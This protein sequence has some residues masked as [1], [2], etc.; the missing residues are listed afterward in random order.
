[1][2]IPMVDCV[3]ADVAQPDQVRY[4][5][6]FE[7]LRVFIWWPCCKDKIVFREGL[8]PWTRSS[9]WRMVDTLSFPSRYAPNNARV[10]CFLAL[11]SPYLVPFYDDLSRPELMTV[12]K[13]FKTGLNTRIFCYSVPKTRKWWPL[14]CSQ[15][16]CIDSTTEPEAVFI[17]WFW[18]VTLEPYERDHAVVVGV[19]RPPPK[20]T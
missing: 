15:A 2:L 1:M 18:Q 12:L 6:F 20:K 14:F 11:F 9:S 10:L 4:S 19:Y 5:V 13:C 7:N 17:C 16:N 8:S 3:L